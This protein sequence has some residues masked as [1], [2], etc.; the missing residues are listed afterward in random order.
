[1]KAV[2]SASVHLEPAI[3]CATLAVGIATMPRRA[4]SAATGAEIK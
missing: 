3:L 2:R 4:A 1:M